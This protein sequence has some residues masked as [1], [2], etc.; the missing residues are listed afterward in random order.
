MEPTI[1]ASTKSCFFSASTLQPQLVEISSQLMW[2]G[3][4]LIHRMRHSVRNHMIKSFCCLNVGNFHGLQSPSDNG[5]GR[6]N[7]KTTADPSTPLRFAQDD[8]A[9]VVPSL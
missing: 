4:D 1:A 3:T 2:T 5:E 9:V 6:T 7:A 8:S